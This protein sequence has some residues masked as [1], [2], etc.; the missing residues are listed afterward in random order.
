VTASEAISPTAHYTGYVWARNDLSH[1]ALSTREG[2]L[3][4]E[5]FRPIQMGAGL[6]GAPS[7]ETY[8]LARHHAIDALL[9]TAIDTH[10]VTQVIEIACGLS[11]RGWRFCDRYGKTIT[12][13]EADLPAM[14]QRKRAA[15]ARMG[16]L[17]Q[18]HRVAEVDA[19]LDHGPLSLAAV[20]AELNPAEGLAIVTEGLLGYLSSDTV[21]GMWRRFAAVLS[22]F[23][24]GPYISDLHI[25][26][27]QSVHVR[28]FRL[29]LSMFVR[30]R[31]S[32]HYG[33]SADATASL[34][35]AGFSSAHLYD[36]A[37][38]APAVRGAGSELV[39]I[40]EASTR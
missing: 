6:A 3:L 9:Q 20:A 33:S 4:F 34:H 23:A 7:L 5:A 39:H 26:G 30:S 22:G 12:Y 31:V 16:S 24:G 40:I 10:G 15:L 29:L 11:P 14:A 25:G 28:W 13:V 2:R 32:L 27:A 35:A 8:L 19:L 17:G 37:E 21:N 38:L 18:H 1:S 36:S